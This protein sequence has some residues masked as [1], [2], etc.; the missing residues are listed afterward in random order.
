MTEI[1]PGDIESVQDESIQYL[2]ADLAMEPDDDSLLEFVIMDRR[3]QKFGSFTYHTLLDS[4]AFSGFELEYDMKRNGLRSY[5]CSVVIKGINMVFPL[6]SG[7][8]DREA[9]N[10]AAAKA[11]ELLARHCYTIKYRGHNV[12][13]FKD[14]FPNR[15]ELENVKVPFAPFQ[16]NSDDDIVQPSDSNNSQTSL[17]QQTSSVDTTKTQ[18]IDSSNTPDSPLQQTESRDTAYVLPQ[19]PKS[20]HTPITQEIVSSDTPNVLKEE[21]ESSDMP[22]TQQFESRCTPRVSLQQTVSSDTSKTQQ[23]N[24]SD[25]QNAFIQQVEARDA[26][27]TTT[28]CDVYKNCSKTNESDSLECNQFHISAVLQKSLQLESSVGYFLNSCENRK[29]NPSNIHKPA[30]QTFVSG[31]LGKEL[32]NRTHCNKDSQSSTVALLKSPIISKT[33]IQQCQSESNVSLNCYDMGKNSPQTPEG[34]ILEFNSLSTPAVVQNSLCMQNTVG[35]LMRSLESKEQTPQCSSNIQKSDLQTFVTGEH[36]G[37]QVNRKQDDNFPLS[38]TVELLNSSDTSWTPIQQSKL[39][40]IIN[41]PIHGNMGKSR[42]DIREGDSVKCNQYTSPAAVQKS[43]HLQNSVGHILNSLGSRNQP[44]QNPSDTYMPISQTFVSGEFGKELVNRRQCNQHPQTSMAQ[45]SESCHD[46]EAPIQ[47]SVPSDIP[48]MILH[49]NMEKNILTVSKSDISTFNQLPASSSVQ[50]SL[51][52]PV[53]G[54]NSFSSFG[55]KM[56]EKM[57]W[58]GGGLGKDGGGIKEPIQVPLVTGRYGIGHKKR[59]EC[60][61]N[62]L[63]YSQK[64]VTAGKE[65]VNIKQSMKLC[66][67]YILSC[68]LQVPLPE[69]K[70]IKK[71]KK[72]EFMPKKRLAKILAPLRKVKDESFRDTICDLITNFIEKENEDELVFTSE[73]SSAQRKIIHEMAQERDLSS[74]SF[75]ENRTRHLVLFKQK[76]VFDYIE[77]LSAN[78][79]PDNIDEK[80][81]IILPE[82]VQN[83]D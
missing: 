52:R 21:N 49:S 47:K 18:Q 43:L 62:P 60:K 67:N 22:K 23:M 56:L 34:N 12:V 11:L 45:I 61:I 44:S 63:Q 40:N 27:L 73:F 15:I 13:S 28:L 42:C 58:K 20:S 33:P 72:A 79:S 5:D 77:R 70:K 9:K 55:S 46:S 32:V 24:L 35:Y 51:P 75:G 26:S 8:S 68:T 10:K 17:I 14:V 41:M 54:E 39:N 29:Q 4:A 3:Y 19:L 53:S 78:K 37:E 1:H 65:Q 50:I 59:I 57:G 16:F 66:N 25:A 69:K 36:S 81:V 7:K 6:A 2:D 76:N 48:N 38:K 83:N 80:Y 64:I 74:I 82:C 30:L 31:G 71:A